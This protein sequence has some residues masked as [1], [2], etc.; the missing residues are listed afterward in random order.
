MSVH[1]RLRVL[2][3]LSV[4][5]I[6]GSVWLVAG[7]QRDAVIGMQGQLR[8]SSDLLTAMLD[9][10]TGVRG[11]ALTGEKSFLEPYVTGQGGF[12]RAMRAAQAGPGREPATAG[13]LRDLTATARQWQA[14][15]RTAVDQVDRRGVRAISRDDA[16]TRKALMDQFRKQDAALRVHVER[17]AQARLQHA[18]WV[19]FGFVMLFST[20]V[21]SLGLF[22]LE[23][24]AR[25]ARARSK[26][27]REYVEALQG[28]DDER[29]AKELLRRR[30][31]RL[32]PG[33]DAVVLTRNASGSS[34][35]AATD[36]AAVPG[37]AG[38]LVDA[39]PRA[40]LA[41]RG[42]HTHERKPGGAPL[43]ACRLCDRVS[44]GSLCVPELVAGEVIGSLLVVKDGQV[45]AAERE[46]ITGA[47]AQ[48][49]PVLANLR[50]LAIA[51]HRAATDPLTKLP[52]AR[53]VQEAL[54]RMVAQ[55]LRSGSPLSAIVI[56]LD[57]F[58]AL[59][60]RHGHQAGDEVL[61]T[62][63]ATLRRG[64]R[65]SDFAGRWGGEE[66]VVLL[67]DTD[68]EGALHAAETMRA[69]FDGMTVPAVTAHITASLGVATLPVHVA[70]GPSLI[71]A[72]DR[73]LYRA[74]ATGRNR[75]VAAV[76]AEEPVPL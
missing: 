45:K 39:T 44:G 73:A 7:Q 53:S 46:S 51:E 63:G 50:N 36:P 56:D 9:Q 19:A 55:S 47:V 59:N 57:H 35:K 15:A 42:G 43:Q 58:K 54:I 38:A 26:Q 24:Q 3:A 61:E 70:D 30:A 33:A 5:V 25:R 18:R 49:A 21:L 16:H 68:L 8:S 31:E 72:A 37:L 69:S 20:T 17:R 48:A 23:R 1:A 6:G 60:D 74:K 67:P 29:E 28:A 64:V 66:F 41:I 32:A 76:P 40:C 52:N 12:E 71:R 2:L 14:N 75:V 10:E 27:R 22:A 11:Y 4:L 65:A 62:F 34:L 13:M